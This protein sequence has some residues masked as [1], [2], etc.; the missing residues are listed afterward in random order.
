MAGI[1]RPEAR[2]RLHSR[3]VASSCRSPA[4]GRYEGQ[5]MAVG[6]PEVGL[7]A[8]GVDAQTTNQVGLA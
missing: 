8:L 7:E 1:G 4:D 3:A 5:A 2:A 6:I